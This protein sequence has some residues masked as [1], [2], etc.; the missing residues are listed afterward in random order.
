MYASLIRSSSV[1]KGGSPITA[2]AALL[3]L[4]LL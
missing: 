2:R 3:L 4:L 1:V